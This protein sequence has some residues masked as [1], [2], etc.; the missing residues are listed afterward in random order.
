MAETYR[1]LLAGLNPQAEAFARR[2][3]TQLNHSVTSVSGIAAAEEALGK[4]EQDLAFVETELN[5]SMPEVIQRLQ[6]VT[7]G[8]AI[9]LVC[10]DFTTGNTIDAFRAGAL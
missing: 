7:P 8:L 9:I 2:H 3:L 6:N 5:E 10:S 4:S 1:I